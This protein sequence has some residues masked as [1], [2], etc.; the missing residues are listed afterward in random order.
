MSQWSSI[1]KRYIHKTVSSPESS[2]VTTNKMYPLAYTDTCLLSTKA[3]PHASQTGSYSKRGEGSGTWN[4]TR[5][6][7]YVGR[8]HGPLFASLRVRKSVIPCLEVSFACVRD[9]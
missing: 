3:T 1:N 4:A 9:A 5:L 8:A 6:W 2:A 7:S